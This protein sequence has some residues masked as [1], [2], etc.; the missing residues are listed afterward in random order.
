[1][2]AQ[3]NI[4]LLYNIMR[5]RQDS[6]TFISRLKVTLVDGFEEEKDLK[7]LED[8]WICNLGTLFGYGG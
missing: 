5:H 3:V 4:I 6:E 2:L 7:R 1:M 8:R